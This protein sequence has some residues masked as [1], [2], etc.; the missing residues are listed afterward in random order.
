MLM[1]NQ[2]FVNVVGCVG[3]ARHLIPDYLKDMLKTACVINID[4]RSTVPNSEI[5]AII[6]SSII[7]SRLNWS[8]ASRVF[9]RLN[10]HELAS[11]RTC[12]SS[13]TSD[14]APKF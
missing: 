7:D 10:S 14:A 12:Q 3:F 6:I 11:L 8:Y 9:H 4:V 13:H 2:Y 1:I 5:L